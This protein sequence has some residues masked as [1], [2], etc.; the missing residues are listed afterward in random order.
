MAAASPRRVG[1][2]GSTVRS[3]QTGQFRA[4]VQAARLLL[5]TDRKQGKASPEWVK[6]LAADGRR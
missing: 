1:T 3:A 6:R 5:V 4:K 2:S